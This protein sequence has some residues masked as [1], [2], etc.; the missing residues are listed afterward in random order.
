MTRRRAVRVAIPV[1][2]CVLA[3][4]AGHGP[5]GAD[6]ATQTSN[7][8]HDPGW[9]R[10]ISWPVGVALLRRSDWNPAANHFEF[11]IFDGDLRREDWPVAV[12][13]GVWATNHGGIPT[14][15]RDRSELYLP[16]SSRS[17][18]TYEVDLGLRRTFGSDARRWQAC[19]GAALVG[20]A[21]ESTFRGDLSPSEYE[22][23]AALGAFVGAGWRSY[24]K[25]LF[26]GL[27][28]REVFGRAKV[29]DYAMDAGGPRLAFE[30][31][32]WHGPPG[33][34]P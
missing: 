14:R 8:P 18:G 29:F 25:R 7:D 32:V 6:G 24:R 27:Q 33:S 21:V 1:V 23:R 15:F 31:G 11:G 26:W 28:A 12:M 2:A 17:C 3:V 19:A 34:R 22:G 10:E 20:A 16:G 9:F 4:L 13:T 30:L 5:A